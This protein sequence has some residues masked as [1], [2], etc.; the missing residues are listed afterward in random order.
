MA[1]GLSGEARKGANMSSRSIETRLQR[2]E[3]HRSPARV[4]FV[5]AGQDDAETAAEIARLEAEHQGETILCVG[6]L[7]RQD[8]AA[9]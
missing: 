3:Q 7:R 1:S 8:E 9:N 4:R 6:W 5:W 2:L